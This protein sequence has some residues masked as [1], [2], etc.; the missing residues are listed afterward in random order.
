MSLTSDRVSVDL[1]VWL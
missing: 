1:W